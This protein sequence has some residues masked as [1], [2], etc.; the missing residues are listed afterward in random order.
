MVDIK[1]EETPDIES[2]DE[3][4]EDV[5]LTVSKQKAQ[6]ELKL[7]HE[8]TKSKREKQ[9]KTIQ[10]RQ[11][12]NKEQRVATGGVKKK[13]SHLPEPV[14][15]QLLEL[16]DEEVKVVI[17]EDAE[18][19]E[20]K[21]TKI[22]FSDDDEDEDSDEEEED[23]EESEG[24]KVTIEAKCLKN[25]EK[26]HVNNAAM[27]FLKNHFYGDRLVRADT[28]KSTLRNGGKRTHVQSKGGTWLK[29]RK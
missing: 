29:K 6:E 28:S 19:R 18:P 13:K 8:I 25:V 7:Q 12:R 4:P 9:K 21:N 14:D 5:S 10:E 23:E 15:E 20:R 1:D 16:V 17:P 26:S 3:E 11:T 2:S 22:V 24:G 27:D